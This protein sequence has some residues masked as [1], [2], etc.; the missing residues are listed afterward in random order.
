[1][2][3]NFERRKENFVCENC[4]HSVVGDG[5]TNH[6]PHCLFSKHVDLNPGD[7]SCSC[8]GSMEPIGVETSRKGHVII[9]RCKKCGVVKRNKSAK[10]DSFET[11]LKI[12]KK[13]AQGE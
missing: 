3:K 8:L 6:C 11:I 1:M 13:G 4:G 7:R 10:G 12:A 5:Y 9:H 2:S